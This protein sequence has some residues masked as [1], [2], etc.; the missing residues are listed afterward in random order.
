MN[1]RSNQ[2]VFPGLFGGL[3]ADTEAEFERNSVRRVSTGT[4]IE[5]FDDSNSLAVSAQFD[6]ELA[7]HTLSIIAGYWDLEYENYLDVDGVPENFLNTTLY[8]DYDQQSLE[9]RLLSPTRQHLRVHRRRALPHQRH[10]DPAALAVRLF[11]GVPRPPYRLAAIGTSSA[12][13]TPGPSTGN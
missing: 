3:T 9:V 1:G 8:E 2:L 7:D 6:T 4:G 5:D 10:A 11:P 12:T 13:P